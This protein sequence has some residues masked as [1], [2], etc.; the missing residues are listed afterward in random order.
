MERN[1]VTL[2]L[3]TALLLAAG[4]LVAQTVIPVAAGQN[5]LLE[6]VATAQAGDIIELTTDGGAYWNDDEIRI[7]VPLTIRAAAGLQNRP[8]LMNNSNE[9]TKDIIRLFDSC[10]LIGLELDGNAEVDSLRVKYAIRTSDDGSQVRQNYVL[11][12]RDCYFHD[13]VFGSDGNAFRAYFN[14]LADTVLFENCMFVNMGKEAVRV[15]DEENE[16]PEFGFFNVNYFEVTNCT[17]ADVVHDAISVYG[18]DSEPNTPGPQVRINHVT[19]NRCGHYGIN[20]KL[21]DD[22]VVKNAIITNNRDF[23]DQTGKTLGGP[24]LTDNASISY[25]DTLNI[26]GDWTGGNPASNHIFNLDPRYAN[27]EQ[28]DFTLVADS[29]LLDKADDG[30]ALGDLRWAPTATSVAITPGAAQPEH[31]ALAQN[32]PNPFN[33]STR[34]AF[35]LARPGHVRLVAYDLGGR[36]VAVL[37]DE[38]RPAGPGVFEWR[39]EGLSSGVYFYRLFVGQTP[40]AVRRAVLVK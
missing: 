26:G 32:Y 20:L 1:H 8:V 4:S 40:V 17:F 16:R 35:E 31:F 19:L 12:V 11:K 39:A 13:V 15:R 7:N 21:V 22:A 29:P 14:T 23:V 25:C 34:I 33:P 37:L 36:Q 9:R 2:L 30:L 5:T 3:S 38:P 24:W 6:A 10:T 18:G 27:P 28:Y